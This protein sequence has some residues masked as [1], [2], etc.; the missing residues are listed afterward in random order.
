MSHRVTL[1]GIRVVQ[2]EEGVRMDQSL[3]CGFLGKEQAS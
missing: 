2:V 3:Y 1:G